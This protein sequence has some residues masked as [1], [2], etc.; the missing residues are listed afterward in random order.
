MWIFILEIAFFTLTLEAR[1][2]IRNYQIFPDIFCQARH[3]PDVNSAGLRQYWYAAQAPARVLDCRYLPG[4][5]LRNNDGR[6][7]A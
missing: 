4:S 6:N 7:G 2:Q 3:Q 1:K 5:L